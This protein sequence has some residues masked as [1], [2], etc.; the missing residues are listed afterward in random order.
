MPGLAFS[1]NLQ[2]YPVQVAARVG[3]CCLQPP[4]MSWAYFVNFSPSDLSR[5]TIGPSGAELDGEGVKQD[6]KGACTNKPPERNSPGA[7]L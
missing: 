4:R 1:S 5:A 2:K 6:R 7:I 3:H